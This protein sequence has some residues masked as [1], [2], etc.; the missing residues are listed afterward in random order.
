[1]VPDCDFDFPKSIYNT[2]DCIYAIIGERKNA[3]VLDYFAGSGTTGHATLLLNQ[4]D[5][6][7]RQVILCT[8]NENGI[9]QDVTYPR[10]K[11]AIN[12]YDDANNGFVDGVVSKLK[13][14]KTTFVPAKATDRNKEKLTKQSV[15]MLCLK[16]NTFE[17][18]LDSDNIKLF[19]N[20][21]HYTGILFDEKEIPN[22]KKKIK[23]FD[24]PVSVY[25]FSLGDDDF[26][27]E[28]SDIKDRVK[29]CSIPAAILRVYKRIFR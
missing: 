22:F 18:V 1:M 6:G 25:V 14:F 15:E 13:Y 4:E 17:S 3:I 21:D 11:A 8:N 12:G 2:Y 7:N 27:E 10:M 16:E 29:V 5:G 19:K 20:K 9:A 26:A 24:L 23:D 28:F